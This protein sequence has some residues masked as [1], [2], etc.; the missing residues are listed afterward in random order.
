MAEDP[1]QMTQRVVDEAADDTISLADSFIASERDAVTPP[2][3]MYGPPGMYPPGAF[4][5]KN[6][7]K[8]RT[9]KV[10]GKVPD[11]LHVLMYYG[12]RHNEIIDTR[13]SDK[14]F[15][16]IPEARGESNPDQD[17]DV[18][19]E[20]IERPVLEILTKVYTND[21]SP[22]PRNRRYP[23]G[24]QEDRPI[25]AAFEG[26]DYR[27]DGYAS[28]E[29]D[30]AA[31]STVAA[32]PVMLIH[33][34]HLINALKVVVKYYPYFNMNG[35]TPSINSPYR[36][37][38]H[39]REELAA[40]RDS[41]PSAHSAEDVETTTKHIDVLLEFLEANMGT[42]LRREE[43]RRTLATPKATYDLFW[44][45]LKPGSV[46]YAKRYDIWSPFVISSVA[47]GDPFSKV[48]ESYRVNC[49]FLESNGAKVTRHME[50]FVVR[51]WL[52]EQAISSLSVIPEAFWVE[53]LS[54]QDGKPMR[55]YQADLGRMYWELLQR[56]T[57]MEH[58]GRLV[59]NS[60][61]LSAAGGQTGF[62]NGRVVCDA[63][64]FNKYHS[65]APDSNDRVRPHELN[66][67][68]RGLPRP[69]PKDHLPRSIPRCPCDTCADLRGEDQ[70]GPYS[71]FE[72]LDPLEDTP[73]ENDLY[74]MV[75]NKSIPGFILGARRWGHLNIANLRP[76]QPNRDAFKYL[77]LEEEVKLTVKALIGKFAT[78][79]DG[80]LSPWGNDF[81]KNKG[82]GRIFLLHGS[83]GVG[84][85]CTAECVAE[86]T[87]RPLISLTSGDLSTRAWSVEDNL[88]YFLEL[89]QRYGALVL[90]D[91]AD[92]YLE[93]RHSADIERNGLVSVFLRALE[94]YRGVLFL[95]TNRV[96]S[97]DRAFMSRIHVALH[98]RNLRDEDRERIW[99][100][101]FDRLESE[102]KGQVHVSAAAREYARHG[103][104][105]LKLK[106]NGRE[107][108]NNMQTALAMAEADGEDEGVVMLA[109]KHLRAVVKMSKGFKDY[110][111]RR[112]GDDSDDAYSGDESDY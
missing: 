47:T 25:T 110:M 101:N 88:N 63:S 12:W 44:L 11:V 49:W 61:A 107:I 103:D 60:P 64:G 84:K 36:V 65:S 3:G 68:R 81:V 109:E 16:R 40:Y 62:M 39:H 112:V 38:Y 56:P 74:Y 99:A 91:E 70:L 73:P 32:Q 94:Y 20:D 10:D 21:A 31:N 104:E 75:L 51:P 111:N 9:L 28:E 57:Y 72:D 46:V 79:I 35:E 85:T 4:K 53:N 27:Y 87:N 90:L 71:D 83:P 100:S 43:E 67:N 26:V 52:G 34:K 17:D 97:F 5:V 30:A 23:P 78:G 48:S 1:V 45:L 41:Q 6:K 14:A 98:Y 29:E 89:G 37:L 13:Q 33:S 69:P 22:P 24:G 80:Q 18:Y 59:N 7:R 76:V 66:S 95:T 102:S 54:A 55:L 77:V 108:R 58:D 92:V 93:R 96:R 50:C 106:W 105:V 19:G 8:K 42:D 15:T 2:P 82:E 86:L